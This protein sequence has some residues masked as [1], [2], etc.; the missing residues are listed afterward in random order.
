VVGIAAVRNIDDVTIEGWASLHMNFRWECQRMPS[1]ATIIPAHGPRL[2]IA[3]RIAA[4]F[5]RLVSATSENL[6]R[7]RNLPSSLVG[8]FGKECFMKR[9]R[10]WTADE[11]QD[12]LELTARGFSV[13]RISARLDR[14][15]SAARGRRYALLRAQAADRDG[16]IE[17]EAAARL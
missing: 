1:F 17:A 16:A 8:C 4:K 7:N 15:T 6:Q 3:R 10:P 11:D 5:K 12:M 13:T 9:V 14:T 2:S